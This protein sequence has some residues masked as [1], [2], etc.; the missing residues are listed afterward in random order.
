MDGKHLAMIIQPF[1]TATKLVELPREAPAMA[2]L[3]P[4]FGWGAHGI[5]VLIIQD[6]A[7]R[8]YSHARHLV[9]ALQGSMKTFL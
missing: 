7:V 3:H 9:S 8:P 6:P 5:L 2:L 1:G 4:L